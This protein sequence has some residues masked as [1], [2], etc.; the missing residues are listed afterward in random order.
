MDQRTDVPLAERQCA[1]CEGAVRKYSADA[2]RTQLESLGGWRLSEDGGR[3]EKRWKMKDFVSAIDFFH[4]VA[5][6]AEQQR[7]HP[8]LHLERYRHVRIELWTHAV[9]GLAENDFVL[10]AKID[11]LPYQ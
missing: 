8:D 6:L 7:H 2:A 5:T 11:Q 10:A 1:A 3:I 9:G 4:R